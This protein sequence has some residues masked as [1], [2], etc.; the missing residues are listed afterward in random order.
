MAKVTSIPPAPKANMPREPAAGVWLSHPTSVSP[1]LTEALH[2]NGVTNAV[3]SPAIPDAETLAGRP[4]EEVLVGVEMVVLD[5][6]VVDVL[7]GEGDTNSF[8][9][10]SLKFKHNENA[11][12]IR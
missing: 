6:V 1:R 2:V 4:E 12:D 8:Q 5:K 11:K 9:S 10:H 3:S 7:N